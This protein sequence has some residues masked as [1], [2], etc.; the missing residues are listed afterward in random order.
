[1]RALCHKNEALGIQRA[2]YGALVVSILSPSRSLPIFMFICLCD[3][4]F[5][6]LYMEIHKVPWLTA[7][8]KCEADQIVNLC[9][10][11]CGNPIINED[12]V[13]IKIK[14]TG[15]L[16]IVLRE[17]GR[18]RAKRGSFPNMSAYL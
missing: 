2:F 6:R 7:M 1:L 11:E 17:H 15:S 8:P 4:N 3:S 18:T 13:S 16:S 12:R 9:H 14:N 5:E 10:T